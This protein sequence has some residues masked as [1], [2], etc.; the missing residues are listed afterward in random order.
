[1]EFAT[2]ADNKMPPS[3]K[4][5]YATPGRARGFCSECGSFLFWHNESKPDIAV[6][7]GTFDKKYLVDGGE[8]GSATLLTRAST[9]LWCAA[10]VSQVTD[11]LQGK[12]WKYDSEGEGAELI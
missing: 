9:H 1:M 11:H 12:T 6:A 3:L 7:V 5:Y 4:R 10:G 8:G 2:G